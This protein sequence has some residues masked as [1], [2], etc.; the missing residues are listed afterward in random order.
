MKRTK[1]LLSQ[2]ICWVE[3]KLY[4]RHQLAVVLSVFV[5]VFTM[6][7]PSVLLFLK[8]ILDILPKLSFELLNFLHIFLLIGTTK[9]LKHFRSNAPVQSHLRS[10]ILLLRKPIAV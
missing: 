6:V 10:F 8:D 9:I 3:L 2:I 4:M 1:F 7:S 5:D